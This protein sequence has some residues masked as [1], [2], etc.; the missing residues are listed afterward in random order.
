MPHHPSG[1]RKKIKKRDRPTRDPE[2]QGDGAPGQPPLAGAIE[3]APDNPTQPETGE[4]A[5][6]PW[7]KRWNG[8]WKGILESIG[9]LAAIAYAIVN[10]FQW[11][12]LRHN[13]Q[14]T[15]RAWVKIDVA[16]PPAP[17]GSFG[18]QTANFGKNAALAV[19]VHTWVE[20]LNKQS[21]PV[22]DESG[23]HFVQAYGLLF[24]GDTDTSSVGGRAALAGGPAPFTER[25]K[26][27]I[28]TGEAY[29]VAY[30]VVT[31]HDQFG[32]HWTRLCDW[33]SYLDTPAHGTANA[34]SCVRYNSVGDGKITF[35]VHV[36][37]E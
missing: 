28:T 25:E 12:D 27:D 4:D 19:R 17:D 29:V 32:Y 37:P 22:L 31:Y 24:P 6:M 8:G 15:E 7:W 20:V 26:E 35:K 21:A 10:Y 30:G 36:P 1:P 3:P 18:I 13:F 34:L 11:S 2:Q 5:S 16:W 9:L 23:N 33:K 14:S